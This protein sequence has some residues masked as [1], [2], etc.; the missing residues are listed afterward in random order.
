MTGSVLNWHVLVLNRSWSPIATTTVRHAIGLMFNGVA[1]AIDTQTFELHPFER[2]VERDV[3]DG[4]PC[5]HGVRTSVLMPEVIV[6]QSYDGS[7]RRALP[8]SR[9]NL[10]RRDRNVCQYCG[11]R[12]EAREV[13]IDHVVPRSRGGRTDWD[14]CVLACLGC[15]HRKANRMPQEAGLVLRRPPERPPW[16]PLLRTPEPRRRPSWKR[17]VSVHDWD[18]VP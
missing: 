6:L 4:A 14:N 1:L 16:S 15:N 13:S 3:P 5:I 10:Y 7:P 12:V 9:Q 8:F 17:F 18:E 11:R 2:W